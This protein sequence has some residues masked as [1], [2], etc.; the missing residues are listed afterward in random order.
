MLVFILIPFSFSQPSI[1]H[2]CAFI[3]PTNIMIK[4]SYIALH[5][6]LYV[7]Q[8]HDVLFFLYSF[9]IHIDT[10]KKQFLP[11]ITLTNHHK[12]Y[13]FHLTSYFLTY[14]P[15]FNDDPST[16]RSP[17]RPLSICSIPCISIYF[18]QVRPV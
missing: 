1:S 8:L 18:S 6:I 9:V 12:T 16:T 3:S 11:V 4:P 2:I 15:F 5:I 7:F 13:I 17:F 14:N 10:S